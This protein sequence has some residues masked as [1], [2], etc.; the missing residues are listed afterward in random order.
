MEICC[1]CC[2]LEE[3][4]AL[5]LNSSCRKPIKCKLPRRQERHAVRQPRR[6]SA[7]RAGLTAKRQG[8]QGTNAVVFLLLYYTVVRFFKSL[9]YCGGYLMI[10]YWWALWLVGY[11]VW[12]TEHGHPLLPRQVPTLIMDTFHHCL[13]IL[14]TCYQPVYFRYVFFLESCNSYWLSPFSPIGFFNSKYLL[15]MW[16]RMVMWIPCH[17]LAEHLL[18]VEL[19]IKTCSYGMRWQYVRRSDSYL[20]LVSST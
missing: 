18:C 20:F 16:W 14:R 12:G 13:F 5:A 7:G 1:C 3:K 11:G 10:Q 4:R 15:L 2:T 9:V 8:H 6:G 17:S 19:T